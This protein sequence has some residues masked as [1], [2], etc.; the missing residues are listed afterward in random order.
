MRCCTWT[1]TSSSW[2]TIPAVIWLAITCCASWQRRSERSLLEG[3]ALRASA[4]TNSPVSLPDATEGRV[5]ALAS[6][7]ARRGARLRVSGR[8]AACF[9]VGV[10]IGTTFL[11]AADDRGSDDV[12]ARAG[13]RLL[14]RQGTWPQSHARLRHRP[15]E[16]ARPAFGHLSNISQLQTWNL[17]PACSSSTA[18]ASIRTQRSGQRRG[19]LRG[20]PAPC[21]PAWRRVDRKRVR[22]SAALRAHGA[23]RPLGAGT[24]RASPSR[25]SSA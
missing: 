13:R 16:P 21:R 23:D 9:R 25:P 22:S 24:C 15:A 11:S 14:R 2:S 18:S 6:K 19:D 12:L 1:S 10:S 20:A 17:P 4:A 8:R 7:P 3:A 5:D